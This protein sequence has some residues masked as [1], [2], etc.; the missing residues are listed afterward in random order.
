[1]RRLEPGGVLYFSCNFRGFVLDE[2]VQRWYDVEDISRWSIPDDF[3][4]N[5]KIHHCYAIRL[6]EPK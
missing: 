2:Q 1:M 4:R 3:R 5:M 6:R